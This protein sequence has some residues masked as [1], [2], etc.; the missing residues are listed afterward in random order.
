MPTMSPTSASPHSILQHS[1]TKK[2]M[3]TRTMPCHA[4]PN[5][6][7]MPT[8]VLLLLWSPSPCQMSSPHITD[9]HHARV[10]PRRSPAQP[11]SHHANPY[12]HHHAQTYPGPL[13]SLSPFQASS[14]FSAEHARHDPKP[15]GT[16]HA[17]ERDVVTTPR[18][19]R[20]GTTRP[21]TRQYTAEPP[22]HP[23]SPRPLLSPAASPRRQL[24]PR[25][26]HW[27]ARSL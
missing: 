23:S 1:K 8:P 10:D 17:L 26:H 16:R 2:I 6:L 24:S 21:W 20:A 14:P 12:A 9:H 15:R 18:L 19:A 3:H 7:T 5:D 22:S 13:L 4:T 11:L 27:L 25:H